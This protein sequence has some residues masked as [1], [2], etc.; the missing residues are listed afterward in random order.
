LFATAGKRSKLERGTAK[1]R[2]ESREGWMKEDREGK[3]REGR[4][5]GEALLTDAKTS[6]I[7]AKV[8]QTTVAVVRFRSMLATRKVSFKLL[9]CSSHCGIIVPIRHYRRGELNKSDASSRSILSTLA[10]VD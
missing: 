7:V 8:K 6:G 10:R 5:K 2:Y 4:A 9:F 3:A 1:N